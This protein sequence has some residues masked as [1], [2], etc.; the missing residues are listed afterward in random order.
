MMPDLGAFPF[1]DRR[2][3][4]SG[5]GGSG[6]TPLAILAVSLGAEVTGSDRNLDRGLSLPSFT[7]LR[8]AGVRLVL[9]VFPETQTVEAIRSLQDRRRLSHED[10]L[11]ANDVLPGFSFPIAQIFD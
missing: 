8:E 5:V 4:F 2:Y 6:M 9:V 10:V 7:A 1:R 3:H 11:D